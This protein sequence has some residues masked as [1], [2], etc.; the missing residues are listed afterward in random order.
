MESGCVCG[1][2][3]KPSTDTSCVKQGLMTMII[4]VLTRANYVET[5]PITVVY[6]VRALL[7]IKQV[8]PAR[9]RHNNLSEPVCYRVQ[10]N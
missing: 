4:V 1:L 8:L 3:K 9:L 7:S 10:S 2:R 6:I 5:L